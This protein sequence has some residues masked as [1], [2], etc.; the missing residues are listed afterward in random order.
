MSPAINISIDPSELTHIQIPSPPP[1]LNYL[2]VINPS[3]SILMTELVG[4][5]IL[6]PLL[7][8]LFFFSTKQLR[9]KPIF[10]LNVVSILLG[11]SMGVTGIWDLYQAITNPQRH[12]SSTH[13]AVLGCFTSIVPL[14]VETILVFRIL[15][16]HPYHATPKWLFTL[17]FLPLALLKIA[18]LVNISMYIKHYLDILRSIEIPIIAGQVAWVAAG[19]NPKI[20]WFLQVVDNTAASCLFLYKLDIRRSL[21]GSKYTA[22]NSSGG[23]YTS[24][25]KGLFWIAISNFIFPVLL[26][27]AQLIF[28]F[29]DPDFV[30]GV[31]VLLI[32]DYVEI[33]GVL[34]ATVWV[35]GTHWSE[36]NMKTGGTSTTLPPMHFASGLLG[37]SVHNPGISIQMEPG[38][39]HESNVSDECKP[40]AI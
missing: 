34:L 26:S 32:N 35:A 17:I 33:I 10:I 14:F 36:D 40:R 3:L 15:A 23:S 2:W 13:F 30:P 22:S 16:V 21:G 9:R 11:I 19:P 12:I 5:S 1:G 25:I 27:I 38:P 28:V 20:E 37:S 29:R 8:I 24:V 7:V 31:I 39:G 4:I 6:L 18:R